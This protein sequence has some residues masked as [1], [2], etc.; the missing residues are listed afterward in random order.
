MQKMIDYV[1]LGEILST[2]IIPS[3]IG[4]YLGYLF[5]IKRPNKKKIENEIRGIK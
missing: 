1:K 5:F 3:I 4:L 2:K